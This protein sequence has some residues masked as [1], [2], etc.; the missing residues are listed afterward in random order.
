M[1]VAIADQN[2]KHQ[3]SDKILQAMSTGKNPHHIGDIAKTDAAILILR[4]DI[5]YPTRT[6]ASNSCCRKNFELFDFSASW[7]KAVSFV[8]LDVD[9]GSSPE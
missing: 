1:H 2:G 5:V 9:S 3:P 8:F 4:V 6:A 7:R